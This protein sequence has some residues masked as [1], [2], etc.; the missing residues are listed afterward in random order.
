[1]RQK[2]KELHIR[3]NDDELA[4]FNKLLKQSGLRQSEFL[5]KT[6]LQNKLIIIPK[7][8]LTEIHKQLK[9]VGNN[10]NQLA[11][12]ANIT[13]NIPGIGFTQACQKELTQICKLLR[14][15]LQKHQ[16]ELL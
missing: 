4:K 7:D 2:N 5:R 1:M 13:G 3:F 15:F 14:Q 16:Q 11:K 8:E 6:T 10:I 9:A 12:M